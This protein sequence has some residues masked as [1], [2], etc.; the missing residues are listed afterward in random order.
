MVRIAP[1]QML[2]CRFAPEIKPSADRSVKSWSY[3]V[4]GH[5]FVCALQKEEDGFQNTWKVSTIASFCFSSH[6]IQTDFSATHSACLI[7]HQYAK[8]FHHLQSFWWMRLS[9]HLP[10]VPLPLAW[11]H[12][13][14]LSLFPPPHPLP[15]QL[16]PGSLINMH[17]KISVLPTMVTSCSDCMTGSAW[18]IRMKTTSYRDPELLSSHY[19]G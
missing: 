4:S 12:P 8:R 7:S 10:G 6:E 9:Q 14:S 3:A 2:F 11:D 5:Q 13:C 18:K 16:H 1:L 17:H 19:V 15:A